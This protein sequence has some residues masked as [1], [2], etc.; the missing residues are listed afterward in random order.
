[1]QGECILS[2]TPL[3]SHQYT[4]GTKHQWR[5]RKNIV[6]I[7]KPLQDFAKI[8]PKLYYYILLIGYR[9]IKYERSK[10]VNQKK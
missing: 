4:N 1:M 7:D 5:I 3:T 8:Y 6:A 9:R 2:Y 10:I